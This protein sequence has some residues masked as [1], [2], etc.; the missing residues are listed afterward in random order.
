MSVFQFKK[1]QLLN[2][3]LSEVWDFISSPSNLKLITP[4]YMGFDIQSEQTSNKM[5]EGQIIVY[6]VS[7]LLKIPMTWVTE[8]THVKEMEYF[9]DEQLIGPYNIWHHEHFIKETENGVL[10]NDILTYSP[11]FGILGKMANS[12]MIKQKINQIFDYR[13]KKLIEIFK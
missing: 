2:A 10:M 8:I 6:K 11:P 13:E 7:P 9:V 12:L 3:S 4:E 1:E 5:Y